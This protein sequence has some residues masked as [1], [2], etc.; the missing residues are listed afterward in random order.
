[1]A[2]CWARLRSRGGRDGPGLCPP[3]EKPS[4]LWGVSSSSTGPAYPWL[5]R[6]PQRRSLRHMPTAREHDIVLLGATGFTGRLV[7]AHLGRRA[8]QPARLAMAGRN[9][10]SLRQVAAALGREVAVVPADTG[11]TASMERLAASTRVL[12]TT[13]GPYSR[14]GAGVV[15]AC[16]AQGTDYLDLTGEPGFYDLTYLRHHD[17]ACRSG[18]RLVH[19][20]GFDSVPHDLGVQFT[21]E[22]L[23]EGAAIDVRGYLKVHGTV[24]GGTLA[25][26]LEVMSAA[27]GAAAL[28]IAR[29]L[30]EPAPPDR[31]VRPASHMVGKSHDTG[32]W[33]VPMPTIDALV[34]ARSARLCRRYGPD[35]RYSP[36]LAVGTPSRAAAVAAGA[37]AMFAAAQVPVLRHKL[38]ALRPPGTGPQE[39]RRDRSWFSLRLYGEGGGRRALTEVT[40]GDPGYGETAKMLAESALCLAFD[41]LPST[42]GQVTTASCMGPAL[43]RRLQE[44]GIQFRTV[45]AL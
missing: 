42:A 40:G 23:P 28:A 31:R 32:N 24:S 21:V 3:S 34:V 45:E 10:D 11:D 15:A 44:V 8:P 2:Y 5:R 19:A 30:V 17:Q 36:F 12:A 7:A 18:A 4:A 41:D 14:L 43:R 29:R 39:E 20:C 16:A 6:G 25:S 13:V 9:E 27:R 1:M 33:A 22:Q 38:Q 26:A 37:A 35:F